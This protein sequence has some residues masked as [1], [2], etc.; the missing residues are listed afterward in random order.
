M[1]VYVKSDYYNMAS[2][3]TA[4]SISSA[5][6][7]EMPVILFCPVVAEWTVLQCLT[8]ICSAKFFS[9]SVSSTAALD[10]VLKYWAAAI[11]FPSSNCR[12]FTS[13]YKHTYTYT[14]C[15]TMQISS[16][17]LGSTQCVLHNACALTPSSVL[18]LTLLFRFISLYFV[19]AFCSLTIHPPSLSLSLGDFGS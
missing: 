19:L 18:P 3:T 13:S 14:P 10:A 7:N 1:Y 8:L 16:A 6:Q 9:S 17:K 11:I 2:F 4:Q 15:A 5:L 12:F